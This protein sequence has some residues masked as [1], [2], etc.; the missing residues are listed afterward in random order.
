MASCGTVTKVGY[1]LAGAGFGAVVALLLAPSTGEHTRK[2]IAR[3]AD[4][5][6]DYLVSKGKEFRDQAEELVEKGK[7]LVTKQKDRLAEA[8]EAG[9]ETA[10]STFMR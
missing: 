5:G 7:D 3:K 4:D 8:L 2:L 1:F 9:K 10:K 6:K